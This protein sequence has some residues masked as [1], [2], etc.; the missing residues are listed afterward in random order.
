M[1]EIEL[2]EHVL[3]NLRQGRPSGYGLLLDDEKST[4]TSIFGMGMYP[5]Y[6]MA[7]RTHEVNGFTVPAPESEA[8]TMGDIYYIPHSPGISWYR[9]FKWLEDKSDKRFLVRGLIH[10]TTEAAIANAKAMLGIDPYAEAE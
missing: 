6:T 2:L 8:L 5:G 9:E 7:P 10:L 1:T 4:A 3:G